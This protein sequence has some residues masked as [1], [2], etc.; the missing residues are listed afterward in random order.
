MQ[1]SERVM[2]YPL[3]CVAFFVGAK[4]AAKKRQQR[5]RFVIIYLT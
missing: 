1:V 2:F 3:A 4:K 5:K